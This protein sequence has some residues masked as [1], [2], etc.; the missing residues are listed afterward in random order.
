[1]ASSPVQTRP[2]AVD[3]SVV[4]AGVGG[5]WIGIR[6]TRLDR[7]GWRHEPMPMPMT[8][9]VRSC[10]NVPVA[11]VANRHQGTYTLCT[12]PV[13]PGQHWEPS[14]PFTTDSST[15]DRTPP[16]R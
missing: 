4:V 7:A 9:T 6:H 5:H 8:N 12:V 1:M 10:K 2:V 3:T 15:Q 14:F 11:V 13:A 16:D